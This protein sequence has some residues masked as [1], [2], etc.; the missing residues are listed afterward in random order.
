MTRG[1]LQTRLRTFFENDTYYTS[2]DFNNSIQDAYDEAAAVTGCIVK[3]VAIDFTANLSYY[4][5]RTLIPDLIGVIAV[6]NRTTK[7]WMYPESTN[8]WD[9]DREDWETCIGTP[10]QFSVI[11]FRYMAIYKKPGSAGYGQMYIFYVASAP[12]LASDDDVLQLDECFIQVL[13][14]YVQVDLLEQGQEWIKA[15]TM[16]GEYQARLQELRV[17][18]NANRNP[19][20]VPGLK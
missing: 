10:E 9:Q 19:G 2:G 17:W 7:L 5:L 4:D 18:V 11:S 1:E 14:N 3:A 15:Q 20:R 13:E 8:R 6:F 12:T 16:F